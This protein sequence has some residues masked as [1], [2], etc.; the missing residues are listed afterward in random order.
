[1]IKILFYSIWR[2]RGNTITLFC[3]S[4]G[5]QCLPNTCIRLLARSGNSYY[6]G[7]LPPELIIRLE[8][9]QTY[10]LR[11]SLTQPCSVQISHTCPPHT[12]NLRHFRTSQRGRILNRSSELRRM[13]DICDD[14]RCVLPLS[15]VNG[16]HGFCGYIIAGLNGSVGGVCLF[17][18]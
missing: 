17:M 15:V 1:M 2:N 6:A 5:Q 7:L 9:R 12:C 10:Y 11:E 8:L 18:A 13:A 16:I 14:V 3:T 4:V